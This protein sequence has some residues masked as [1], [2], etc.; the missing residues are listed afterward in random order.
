LVGDPLDRDADFY[1]LTQNSDR[2]WDASDSASISSKS[3]NRYAE[4]L[5]L[6]NVKAQKRWVLWQIPLGN[7][8][9][10]N[11]YN[12]GGASEGYKDNRAEYF[13][14][15]GTAHIEKFAN[16]GV[17]ALLF[18]AGAGGQSTYTNDQYADGQLFMKSRAG[19]IV[20][21]GGVA[22]TTGGTGTPTCSPVT[23]SGA[24]LSGDYFSGTTLTTK[25]LSRTDANVDFQWGTASPAAGIPGDS[26]SV[27]WTGQVSPRFSGP[28]TFYTSSD[29]GVRLWVNGQQ[30]VNNWTDH[31]TTE[32]SGTISLVA[33]QKYDLKLEYYDATGGAT[34]RLLWSSSCEPKAAVPKSQLYP[35]AIAAGDTAA[36]NFES[37]T[38]GW[39]AS[40]TGVANVARS[41]D[42]AFAGSGSLKVT[43]GSASADGYAKL[44]NPSVPAGATVTFH[45]WIPTGSS[46]SAVQ[47]YVLQGAAGGWAW[48][49][50][51]RTA[52]SLQSGSWNTITVAVPSNA[53]A[54]A[55]LGVMFTTSGSGAGAAAYVDSVSY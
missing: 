4:W 1:R 17:V 28:T 53:A 5:R 10:K 38:Q 34:A 42:R 37:G 43:L 19:A 29:D 3:F 41:V 2:W 27:R 11:V 21:A 35:A 6:W 26:F 32:N 30:L 25:V 48:T 52:S 49:G 31:G 16:S 40:G 51:W 9:S 55:E 24:G 36:Y 47:P 13:F 14:G 15:A 46:L 50:S 44:S 22:L 45:V 18:G 23:G 20:N 8:S 7:S 54:L 39:A 33:G 12:N